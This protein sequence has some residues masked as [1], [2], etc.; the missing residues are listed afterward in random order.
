MKYT[1]SKDMFEPENEI[2]F[3]GLT[4]Q[5]IGYVF[6]EKNGFLATTAGK[7]GLAAS[8]NKPELA[9]GYIA[10]CVYGRESHKKDTSCKQLNLF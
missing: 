1:I 4:G 5:P 7:N 3:D 6:K 2:L 9:R 10:A 8:F